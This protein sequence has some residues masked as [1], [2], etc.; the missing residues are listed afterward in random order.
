M[1]AQRDGASDGPH[2]GIIEKLVVVAAQ[3]RNGIILLCHHTRHMDHGQERGVSGGTWSPRGGKS[4]EVPKA[5]SRGEP[6]SSE[7]SSD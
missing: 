3:L 7:H 5:S 1:C 2:D 4:L 6:T